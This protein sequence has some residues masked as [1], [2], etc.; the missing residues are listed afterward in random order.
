MQEA[1]Q[2]CLW[3]LHIRVPQVS[4]LVQRVRP[5]REER[6]RH[7]LRLQQVVSRQRLGLLLRGLLLLLP[8]LLLLQG[9]R[10][11]RELLLCLLSLRLLRG[12]LGGLRLR[13]GLLLALRL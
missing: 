7:L 12:R 9:S 5:L 11:L 1:V 3:L 6:G 13:L 10:L 8:G 4:L 2:R